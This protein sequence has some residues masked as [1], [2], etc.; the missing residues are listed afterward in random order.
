MVASPSVTYRGNVLLRADLVGEGDDRGWRVL[1]RVNYGDLPAVGESLAYRWKA[2]E[3]S[4]KTLSK[5]NPVAAEKALSDPFLMYNGHWWKPA[6][7]LEHEHVVPAWFFGVRADLEPLVAGPLLTV[8]DVLEQVPVNRIGNVPPV[9]WLAVRDISGDAG[10]HWAHAL[11]EALR[12][13]SEAVRT[14][15]EQS[16]VPAALYTKG[17]FRV[18]MGQPVRWDASAT[19]ALRITQV[20]MVSSKPTVAATYLE[21]THDV[22]KRVFPIFQNLNRKYAGSAV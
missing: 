19:D 9:A 11:A 12:D 10:T 17:Y 1:A 8:N 6:W 22:F 5:V 4:L 14:R 21:A 7:G 3:R 18:G 20:A 15:A 2:A 16:G 13:A